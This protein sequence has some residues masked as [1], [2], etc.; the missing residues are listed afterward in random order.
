VNGRHATG[1]LFLIVGL[2]GLATPVAAQ[3]PAR[4]GRIE[5]AV[6]GRWD[7]SM[8]VSAGSAV[9]TAASGGDYPLFA[10]RTDW[11]RALFFDARI[12]V[13]VWKRVRGE[14]A[15]GYGEAR[16]V[17]NV[18]GDVEAGSA[19]A[20][21]SVQ[22]WLFEGQVAVDLR[23]DRADHRVVPFVGAGGGSA[24]YVHQGRTLVETGR[25]VF[26]DAGV[27]LVLS[28]PVGTPV[29]AFGVR[30]EGRLSAVSGGLLQEERTEVVPGFGFS[31]FVRY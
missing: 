2:I 5:L 16:L 10:A 1:A 4:F 8:P 3:E 13:R 14:G 28:R 25:T 15:L 24:R 23:E 12:G 21:E 17:T 27:E 30:V 9:L 22:R 31:V 19:Q 7:T 26:V 18:S 29:K 6:G 11:E 20:Q